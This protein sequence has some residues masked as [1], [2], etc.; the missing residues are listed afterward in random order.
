[1]LGALYY[2]GLHADAQPVELTR[3]DALLQM[4]IGDETRSWPLASLVIRPAV[5]MIPCRVELPDGGLLEI[6]DV[7]QARA[8]FHQ[9]RSWVERLEAHWRFALLSVLTTVAALAAAYVWGLPWAADRASVLVPQAW[10]Q[11]LGSETLSAL[12]EHWFTA[13]SLPAARQQALR[14]Q[15]AR[16]LALPA[17]C[18]QLLFR[19][20]GAIGANA[21][22][23]PGGTLLV[24]DELVALARDD[25]EIL[26]VLAHETGHIQGRHSVRML[27]RA[28]GVGVS[29]ALL[30]GDV[31][32]LGSVL[33][34]APAM[35]MQL[36]YSRE[37]EEEAD[38]AA[39][40]SLVAAGIAP[41]R[42][43]DILNRMTAKKSATQSIPRWLTTH[44][45]TARRT[46]AFGA[47]CPAAPMVKL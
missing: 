45:D 21:L 6:A 41:C 4:R 28:S 1:M 9:P 12:D 18:C 37:F 33:T 44:P 17:N 40:R 34:S 47:A 36:S 39:L 22:A 14:D 42:F 26:A 11:K 2:D 25:E 30:T 19:R 13:S 46:K 7:E 43:S 16:R 3:T 32:T 31:G 8:F 29:I 23:L 38:A 27:L 5:G 20:G 10:E 35:L 15:F 24:T